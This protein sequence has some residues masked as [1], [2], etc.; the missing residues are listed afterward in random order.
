VGTPAAGLAG[1]VAVW[2]AAVAVFDIAPYV[3][4]TPGQVAT[5]AAARPGYLAANGLV[6]LTETLTGFAL[7]GAGGIAVGTALA[8]SRLVEQAL[9]PVLVA[10]NALPK[11]AFAPLL[12]VWLGFG[13]TPKVIMVVLMCFLPMV[14]ST[15]A[16]LTCTPADLV[17]LARSLCATRWRTF[18]RI[19]LP[20]AL[21]QIMVALK[22]AMPL[23]VVGALVGEL[24]G[25]QAGLG[26]VI[27]TTGA[28][29]SLAFA[30]AVL[31][32]AIAIV[33]HYLLVAAE[34]LLLPWLRETT[35]DQPT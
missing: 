22:T 19:R 9:T 32:A 12:V 35:T 13:T 10:L 7:A 27:Q 16:G 30:A 26:F 20:A 2:W 31:V 15:V 23:A 29:A 33:L 34:R 18:T 21:A 4:P 5:A 1:V 3:L 14:L 11:L 24:F 17:E 6:T 25:A 28:D 8:A